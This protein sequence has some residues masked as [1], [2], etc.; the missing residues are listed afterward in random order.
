MASRYR[1]D[2][3]NDATRHVLASTLSIPAVL[4]LGV[5]VGV[6]GAWLLM[7]T[8]FT[9]VYAL[10]WA[11]ADELSLLDAR[12]DLTFA[13]F[14]HVAVQLSTAFSLS[15]AR[16]HSRR[17]RRTT[18]VHSLVGFCFSTIIVALLVALIAS[19]GG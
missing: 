10:A 2:L 6:V 14:A 4:A 15:G 7:T 3:A 18:T 8:A 16:V 1:L 17:L 12:E 5:V 13:D 11:R 9:S 19:S